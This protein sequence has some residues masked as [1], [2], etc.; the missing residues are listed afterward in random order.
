MISFK[1]FEF[2]IAQEIYYP[3]IQ[4]LIKNNQR[5]VGKTSLMAVAFLETAF[6]HVG[7]EVRVFDHQIDHDSVN[8]IAAIT[9]LF[10]DIDYDGF[11]NSKLRYCLRTTDTHI[12]VTLLE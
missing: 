9:E 12:K 11:N 1:K 2:G 4:W 3:G 8:I 7:E 10:Y 5:K 6:K